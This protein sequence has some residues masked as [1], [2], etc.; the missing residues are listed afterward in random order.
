MNSH[1]G[2]LIRPTWIQGSLS[3]ASFSLCPQQSQKWKDILDWSAAR[4]SFL[5]ALSLAKTSLET[6]HCSIPYSLC[7]NV[8]GIWLANKRT[9]LFGSQTT[10]PHGMILLVWYS[11][12][13]PPPVLL[14]CVQEICLSNQHNFW[15]SICILSVQVSLTTSA[16][17][18]VTNIWELSSCWGSGVLKN[19]KMTA[20]F[21]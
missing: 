10:L 14:S 20:C 12:T 21:S 16:N 4:Y 5:W 8:F 11:P 2:I 13:L 3:K 6:H 15:K 9:E 19:S 1:A 17:T 18:A 7:N